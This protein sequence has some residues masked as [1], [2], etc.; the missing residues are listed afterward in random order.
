MRIG[1]GLSIVGPGPAIASVTLGG[2][3]GVSYLLNDTFTDTDGVSLSSHTPDIGGPWTQTGSLSI[4][5]NKAQ[6]ASLAATR[7]FAFATAPTSANGYTQADL[8]IVGSGDLGV[9]VNIQSVDTL[10]MAWYSTGIVYLYEQTSKEAFTSRG[11]WSGTPTTLRAVTNGDTIEVWCD[12]VLRITYTVAG[13]PYKSSAV[14]GLM[15][16]GT[17]PTGSRFDNVLAGV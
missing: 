9:I 10:W 1:L 8:T 3:S 11:T 6:F 15:V 5:S 2:V 4:S 13:R 14:S 17:T 12:G 7:N 16:F